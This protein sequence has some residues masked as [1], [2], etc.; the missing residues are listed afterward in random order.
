MVIK[1]DIC[2]FSEWKIYPGKGV[3]YV[4]KDGRPFL[5]LS[6]RA[7]MFGLRYALLIILVNSKL[8]DLDGQPHGEDFIRKSSN[9]T[10]ANLRRRRQSDSKEPSKVS[11]L[12][13]SRRWKPPDLKIKRHW[14]SKLSEKSKIERRPKS[15]RSKPK[16]KL[17]TLTKTPSKKP[18]T[19]PPK[20]PRRRPLARR[21]NDSVPSWL[22]SY[23][24]L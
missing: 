2:S 18:K 24:N 8:K 10:L 11:L 23:L 20:R 1:T 7:R 6:K 4:A 5:Y 13:P 15:P 14:L 9:P 19:R 16:E 17:P 12:I 3:R 21:T 22:A